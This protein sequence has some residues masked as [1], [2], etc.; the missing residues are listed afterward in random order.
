MSIHRNVKH[1]T[2]STVPIPLQTILLSTLAIVIGIDVH[3]GLEA[4][5]AWQIAQ[6]R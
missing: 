1:N 6:L 2:L 3:I 4:G 5:G